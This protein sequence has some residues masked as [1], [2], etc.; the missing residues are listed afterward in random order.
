MSRIQIF[1]LA[2]CVLTATAGCRNRCNNACGGGLFAGNATIPAPPT[3]SLNI[4]S[5][6][7]NQPYYVPGTN[8][9]A[10][11]N[12]NTYA[13]TPA[14]SPTLPNRWEP[15]NNTTGNG[16]G[17]SNSGSTGQSVLAAPTTFVESSPSYPPG[18]RTAANTTLPGAGLSYTDSTNYQTT[19]TDE[20]RDGSRLPVTDASNV[21]A[22]AANF[23]AGNMNRLAQLPQ[24]MA[25]RYPTTFNSTASV[26]QPYAGAPSGVVYGNGQPVYLGTP[27][28]SGNPGLYSA[29]VYPGQLNGQPR[30]LGAPTAVSGPTVLAQATTT[31]DPSS[32]SQYGWRD[33]ELSTSSDSLNR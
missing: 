10:P 2:C 30:Y 12:P 6:A 20:T 27:V 24:P 14:N 28:V 32:G 21:R 31:Y 19:R 11:A 13:P 1:A 17:S 8:T 22:P 16:S 18:Y 9:V 33:R 25:P 3:Y 15:K 7:R 4:P 29:P 26:S 23:P 5:V